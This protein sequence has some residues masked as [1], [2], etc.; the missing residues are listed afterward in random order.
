LEAGSRFHYGLAG[1]V[2]AGA[3][4]ADDSHS[5]S[6]QMTDKGK[7]ALEMLEEAVH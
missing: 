2:L 1:I 6:R 5:I 7:P 3:D 4:P